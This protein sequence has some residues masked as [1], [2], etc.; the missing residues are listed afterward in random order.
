MILDLGDWKY[1][2]GDEDLLHHVT[3]Q[4]GEAEPKIDLAPLLECAANRH[5]GE[6]SRAGVKIKVTKAGRIRADTAPVAPVD[7]TLFNT[8]G[9]A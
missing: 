9:K 5:N 3:L 8:E 6:T 1:L 7:T 2:T 4:I